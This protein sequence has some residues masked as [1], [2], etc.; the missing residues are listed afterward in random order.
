LIE[1][2]ILR[3]IVIYV[4]I[5][6]G[7]LVILAA[8]LGRIFEDRITQYVITEL[9]KQIRTEA[10]VADVK[11][12]FLKK[13][14][15]ASLEL[16]DIVIHS[17]SR[18]DTLLDARSLYL[19]LNILRLLKR[20]YILKEVHGHSGRL[21]L[22]V[23][24]NREKNYVFWEKR[25]DTPDE[26]FLLDINNLKMTDIELSFENRATDMSIAGIIKKGRF[27]G[28]FSMDT[29]ELNA[30]IDGLL[31]HYT[32]KGARYFQDQKISTSASLSIDPLTLQVLSAD[33]NLDGQLLDVSGKIIRP[34]PL[35][36]DLTITGRQL[37][38]GMVLH[39]G[40]IKGIPEDLEAGGAVACT[41]SLTGMAS[42]TQLPRIDASFSLKDGWM[43][44]SVFPYGIRKF[45]TE[46]QY[47]NGDRQGPESTRITLGNASLLYGNSR[48]GGDYDILDLTHPR[49]D[50]TIR[51]ELDLADIPSLVDIDS[52]FRDMDGLLTAE[53]RLQGTQA[54]LLKVEKPEWLRLRYDARLRLDGVNLGLD[55]KS[56]DLT[57]LTGELTFTD[58]L[59][60]RSMK[61][62]IEDIEANLSGRVD[63]LLE[64]LLT[65]SA[66][67][68]LDLD[69]YVSQADLNSLR[70]LKRNKNL[71]GATK[72][73]IQLPDRL[74]VK[75]RYWIDELRVNKFHASQLTGELAYKP[76][77]LSIHRLDLHSMQGQIKTEGMLEQQRNHHFLVRSISDVTRI[78]ISRTFDSF[79]N[80]GQ[81]FI[82]GKHLK[83][84]FSGLVN[85]SAA[86]NEKMQ[87]KKE[88]ILADC[89]I[90]I[91][92]GE[93]NGFEP[94]RKLSR[95]IDVEE[96]EDIT[97]STLSNQ[98][99]IRNAEVIIPKMD[100]HS[101]AF[102]ITGSG[103]HGFDKNFTYKVKVSLSEI[104]S[105][106][107]RRPNKQETEFGIIED[108]GLGRVFIPLIIEGSDQGTEVRYDKRGAVQNV[109]E[110]F[111]A[112]K[113]ELR[114]ILKEEFGLFQKD[115]TLGVDQEVGREN[116]FLLE[117]EEEDESRFE[118]DTG[119]KSV[120]RG[121]EPFTIVWDDEEESDT[122][123]VEKKKR[124]RRK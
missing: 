90:V 24:Q 34:R 22:L 73:T 108:D 38:L 122:V 28:N 103:L 117:W 98:V 107:A 65:E 54:S 21:H 89:D 32:K 74:Y 7:A 70:S 113:Q 80:F 51:A 1:L 30:G 48:L 121:R 20:Q 88:T 112:E 36:Y 83:G 52:V 57:N 64:F 71:S 3:K 77:R 5:S 50:Y 45:S 75:T 47:T 93:L 11:L 99:F 116:R 42:R 111:K 101:S 119:K 25:E 109:K 17:A 33:L 23:D 104:L 39:A 53:I 100:I 35:E 79:D 86:L 10:S 120:K 43:K 110:Q 62:N 4:S 123:T 13:F 58:H 16:K 102:D 84:E 12:S 81:D 55:Y 59:M 95:Y 40:L 118:S 41:V 115:S 124:R 82:M 46:G 31:H 97:F 6:A 94:M 49:I 96:L 85:F 44:S 29:Y 61:G 69:I 37:D 15:D 106:K 56:L 14:P 60:I 92:D 76:R 27:R 66:N 18:T 114:E 78:D 63:N 91:Q 2:K 67:L 8:L 105:K 9:N 72:D 19:R 26:T 87:I 68:W